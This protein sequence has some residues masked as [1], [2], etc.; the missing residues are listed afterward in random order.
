MYQGVETVRNVSSLMAADT[1]Y[2]LER[3]Y[4]TWQED[5]TASVAAQM[6]YS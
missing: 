6:H 2:A 4:G 1:V 5:P 3:Q